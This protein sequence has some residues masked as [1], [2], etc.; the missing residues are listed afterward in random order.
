MSK[1]EGDTYSAQ[2]V[3]AQGPNAHAHDM[4]FTQTGNQTSSNI[5]LLALANELS[6]LRAKLKE[7][8]QSPEHDTTIGMVA[9]AEV[10]ARK[11]DRSKSLE[12][13]S[14]IGEYGLNVAKEIG[15]NVAVVAIKS[16]LGIP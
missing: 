10:E 6:I 3:G 13:L 5:D 1:K 16:A 8:A 2:Q 12:Y 4:N 7:T 14:K 15:V 11:G 9:S